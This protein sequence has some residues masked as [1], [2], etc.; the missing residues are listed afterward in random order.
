MH[1]IV[2]LV[3]GAVPE[4]PTDD[5]PSVS[6]SLASITFLQ[7]RIESYASKWTSEPLRQ[8]LSINGASTLAP[9]RLRVG[10]IWSGRARGRHEDFQDGHF[11][12]LPY[13]LG[14]DCPS[15]TTH[16]AMFPRWI[17]ATG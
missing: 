4:I 17:T 16:H 11:T 1:K 8:R 7:G 3:M 6:Q 9:D 10:R 13:N 12:R 14:G 5:N 15:Q 2:G